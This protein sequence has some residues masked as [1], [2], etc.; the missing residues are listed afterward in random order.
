MS[1]RK[2]LAEHP[3][4]FYE[5]SEDG[6]S[7]GAAYEDG[8]EAGSGS[9]LGPFD[10]FAIC[11]AFS[12]R[13]AS[14]FIVTC[15]KETAGL[16]LWES[17]RH[18]WSVSLPL[19]SPVL[20]KRLASRRE[21]CSGSAAVGADWIRRSSINQ[22]PVAALFTRH[23]VVALPPHQA[24]VLMLRLAAWRSSSQFDLLTFS[25]PVLFYFFPLRTGSVNP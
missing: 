12:C 7:A 16:L 17:R 8:Q 23:L 2:L 18:D 19:C 9:A 22:V 20:Q 6:V 11:E 1:R 24:V 10:D 21:R 15:R 13:P 3:A 25:F 4:A 5:G 14:V